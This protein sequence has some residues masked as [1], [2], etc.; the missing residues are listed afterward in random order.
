MCLPKEKNV[1]TNEIPVSRMQSLVKVIE[2][3]TSSVENLY[4]DR[5]RGIRHGDTDV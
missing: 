4:S 3:Y 5:Y 1:L 2:S